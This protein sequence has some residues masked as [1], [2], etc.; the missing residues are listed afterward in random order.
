MPARGLFY[1]FKGFGIGVTVAKSAGDAARRGCQHTD[2]VYSWLQVFEVEAR[3]LCVAGSMGRGN[4]G[5]MCL[6]VVEM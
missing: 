2:A 1:R 5:M 3:P 4:C 6:G